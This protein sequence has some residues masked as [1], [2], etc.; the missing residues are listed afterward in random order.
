MSPT[1]IITDPVGQGFNIKECHNMQSR[2]TCQLMPLFM[3]SMENTEKHKTIYKRATSIGYVKVT[4]EIL[5]KN[6][7]YP[8]VSN[9]KYFSTPANTALVHPGALSALKTILQRTAPYLSKKN[10]NSVSAKKNT[11]QISL[12]ALITPGTGLLKKRR[13]K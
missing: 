7:D 12:V 1:Q 11:Q 4:I 9:T 3:I 10:Q 8:S 2:K 6:T 5:R 13:R